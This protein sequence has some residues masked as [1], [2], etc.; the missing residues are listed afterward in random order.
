MALGIDAEAHMGAMSIDKPTVAVLGSGIDVIAPKTNTNIYNYMLTNGAIYS[1]YPPGTP[2][3]P[4]NYPRR[5]RII[6]ALSVG[7]LVV[8]AHKNSGALI[9]ANYALKQG[10]DIYAVPNTADNAKGDG[11]NKLIKEGAVLTT[12]AV[13]I[14]NEYKGQYIKEDIVTFDE[15]TYNKEFLSEDFVERFDDLTPVEEVIAKS[16]GTKAMDVDEISE[17]SRIPV[18]YVLSSLTM[19]EIKGVIKSV[20]GK[21]YVLNIN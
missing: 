1:E 7:L 13:D 19:L 9:T 15:E 3:R 6:S 8:E 20:P 10:K 16:I 21:G 2:G 5:N 14:L 11:T 18:D 12:C 4:V 17:I